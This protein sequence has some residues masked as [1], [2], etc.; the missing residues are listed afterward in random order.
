[1][2]R[3]RVR[4]LGGLLLA[5][6]V[7]SAPAQD[8][9]QALDAAGDDARGQP[10]AKL[11]AVVVTGTRIPRIQVEGPLPISV[12]ERSELLRGGQPSLADAVRDLPWNSFG[13][14][15]DIPNSDTPNLS[16]PRLRGLGSKYTLTLLD[17]QRLPGVASHLGGAASSL[18]G[19]PL[20]AIERVE[21]LRDGASAVYGSDAIGGVLNLITRRGGTAPEFALQWDE[22][23]D[24]GGGAWRASFAA[25]HGFA[26]GDLLVALEAEDRTPLL[27]AQRDYFIENA[28]TSMSSNPGSFRRVNPATGDFV[29]FFQPDA[30]CPAEFDTD[31]VFPSSAVRAFGPN[32]F[33]VFRF[34]DFNAE[35]A[36]YEGRSAFVGWRRDLDGERSAFARAL[37]IDGDGTTQLAPSPAGRLSISAT[38]PGNPTLGERGPGLGWPLALNYRLTPLGPRVTTIDE[39]SWHLLAGVEGL[40]DWS[41]GGQW[42]FAGFHNRYRQASEGV[43]GYALQSAF[44]AALSDGRFDPFA[45][46]PGDASGLEDALYQPWSRSRSR[47]SGLELSLAF[48][49]PFPFDLRLSHAYGVDLRRDQ[50]GADV[51]PGTLAGLVIG[52]GSA[53]PPQGATR[54]YGGVYGEWFAPLGA[55]WELS[56]AARYD[57]YQDAGGRLSPKLAAAFRPGEVWLLRG[58]LGRGFQAPDLESAYGS[59]LTATGGA[60]DPI[61]CAANPGDPVACDQRFFELDIVPNPE[62]GPERSRHAS[63]GALWQPADAFE[64]SLD[65]VRTRVAGQ[66]GTISTHDA[67]QAEFDCT[68]VLRDCTFLRDGRVT[69]DGFGNLERVVLPYI[70]IAGTRTAAVDLE[71]GARAG[72]GV[73]DFAFRLRASRVLNFEEQSLPTSPRQEFL[74]ANGFPRW[75]GSADLDWEAGAYG[76]TF[77]VE[78]TA[79]FAACTVPRVAGTPRDP[80]CAVRVGSHAEL[81]GQLRWRP[82]WGGEI[83]L[84]GRNLRD[85]P[86]AFDPQGGYSYGLFDPAGRVWYLR[87]RHEF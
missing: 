83:A 60:V 81:N 53:A 58:A 30:R 54:N 21:V 18:T 42:Q 62:L 33:C 32:R 75:R 48:D 3:R 27:G 77:G 47:A 20:I 1:M 76:A 24:P 87:W 82:S 51:D 25:G 78:H 56:L 22:P 26:Q 65:Y 7:S 61:E 37:E 84:G 50:F 69:R 17:G 72:T 38:H 45:A 70:N 68:R 63:I 35:R 67:L 46:L 57:H 66:I 11:D 59:G 73:G 41:E 49:T 28:A 31:P 10:E 52:Q 44:Q 9:A 16:L 40:L 80:T 23:E 34:R 8:A 55:H 5:V 29:G 6:V 2:K 79:G 13:S 36:G 71:I 14:L 39:T 86:P 64:M 43:A 4:P 19:I 85:R 12:V 15:G 74:D